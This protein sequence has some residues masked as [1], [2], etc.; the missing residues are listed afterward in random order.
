MLE[1]N[2]GISTPS[3]HSEQISSKWARVL[4]QEE[5]PYTVYIRTNSSRLFMTPFAD[6]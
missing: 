3:F 4:S 1:V 5:C 6:A 2:Q